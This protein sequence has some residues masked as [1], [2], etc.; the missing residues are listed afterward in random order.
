MPE[1]HALLMCVVLLVLQL[2]ALL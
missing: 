2:P 1:V